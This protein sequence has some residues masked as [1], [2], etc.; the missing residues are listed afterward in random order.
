MP[1]APENATPGPQAAS[2]PACLLER[3]IGRPAATWAAEL[4]DGVA[5]AEELRLIR[6]LIES[7]GHKGYSKNLADLFIRRACSGNPLVISFA[8]QK[9][10]LFEWHK[11]LK[12]GIITQKCL[13]KDQV[14]QVRGPARP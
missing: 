11:V 5:T 8:C 2:L 9:R 13:R 3:L 1:S 6:T 4:R 14:V 10:E 7:D 12:E